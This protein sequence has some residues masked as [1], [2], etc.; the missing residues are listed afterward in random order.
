[1]INIMDVGLQSKFWK[2]NALPSAQFKHENL[3]H[4]DRFW[5]VTWAN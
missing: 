3:N 2:K 5:R 4:D 1:M